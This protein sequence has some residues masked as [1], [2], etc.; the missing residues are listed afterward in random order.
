MMKMIMIFMMEKKKM[1]HVEEYLKQIFERSI[2][3]SEI[4]GDRLSAYFLPNLAKTIFRL[5]KDFPL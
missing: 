4:K 5:C 3:N 1:T 2:L